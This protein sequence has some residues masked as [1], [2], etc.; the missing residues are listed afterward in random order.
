MGCKIPY[1]YEFINTNLGKTWHNGDY[2]KSRKT[3]LLDRELAKSPLAMEYIEQCSA[4]KQLEA[5]LEETYTRIKNA[6]TALEQAKKECEDARRQERIKRYELRYAHRLA[7]GAELAKQ[8]G[9][10]STQHL[11]SKCPSENCPG[12]L[13]NQHMC[14]TCGVQTCNKCLELKE[15]EEEGD[16]EHVCDPN[17]LETIKMLRADTKPCPKC[18]TPIHKIEGC[19]QMWCTKC[20]T[21]FHYRTL[22]IL[23]ETIHNPHYT[24]WVANNINVNHAQNPCDEEDPIRRIGRTFVDAESRAICM[25]IQRFKNHAEQVVL[26]SIATRLRH[27]SDDPQTVRVRLAKHLQGLLPVS[28]LQTALFSSNKQRQRWANTQELWNTF[29]N[30]LQILLNNAI[31]E[32]DAQTLVPQTKKLVDYTNSEMERINKIYNNKVQFRIELEITTSRAGVTV[33][34]LTNARD[35]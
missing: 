14:V 3:V 27:A 13:N 31:I 11:Y 26:P 15:G 29:I 20:H 16:K 10:K 24:E 23:K 7:K 21:T 22:E 5:E 30:T 34:R 18:A 33:V 32:K 6:K 17:I 12:M 8:G 4:V 2:K 35:E 19:Y 9:T 25:E 28:R 1:T